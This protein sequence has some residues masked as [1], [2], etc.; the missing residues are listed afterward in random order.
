MAKLTIEEHR[1]LLKARDIIFDLNMVA[2]KEKDSKMEKA[3]NQVWE[4]INKIFDLEKEAR[5]A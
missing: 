4:G 3:T 5:N 1:A 2:Y